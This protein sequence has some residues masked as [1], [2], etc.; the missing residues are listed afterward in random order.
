MHASTNHDAVKGQRVGITGMFDLY[1][2]ALAV[3][4]HAQDFV[5]VED[6]DAQ[7][8]AS[9]GQAIGELVDVAGGVAFG[10]VTTVVIA[11][12]GGLNGLDLFWRH[13]AA[14]QAALGQQFGDLASMVEALFVA[15]KMQN[16]L[17]LVVELDALGLGPCKVVLARFDG[18]LRGCDGVLTV[19]GHGGHELGHPA[20]LVPGGGGV[21]QQ[22]RVIFE[23]PLQTLDDRGRVGPDFGVGGRQLT[24][25]GIRRF[26]AGVAVFLDQGDV[27][28]LLNQ[29]IRGGDARD[30]ATDNN[31]VLF[32]EAFLSWIRLKQ[33]D[34]LRTGCAWHDPLCLKPERFT[35][36]EACS[37][38]GPG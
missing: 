23:H 29:G 17:A 13:G 7:A 21:H 32:H 26:H 14:W 30:A 24:A 12:Q 34:T 9:F 11:V 27:K 6:L 16:A 19:L 18:Q 38:G 36:Y 25:V 15:V 1:K 4:G 20:E 2:S 37:C 35:S 8:L 10:E 5:F 31:H 28:T 22:G 3:G 33:V